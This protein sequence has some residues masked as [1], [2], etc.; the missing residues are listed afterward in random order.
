MKRPRKRLDTAQRGL[1]LQEER[2]EAASKPSVLSH[3]FFLADDPRGLYVGEE[4]LDSYLRRNRL[5]WVIRLRSLLEGLDYS[6]LMGPYKATG[7]RAVSPRA[8]L[9][10]IVYGI[11]E[12]QSSLRELE[13]LAVRDVGAWW[14][15][16]GN[17]PD[18]STIGKFIQT[19][20]EALS[21]EF[22]MGLV[23][24]LGGKMGLRAGA[25]AADGTVIEAAASRYSLIRAEAAREAAETARR[26]AESQAGNLEAAQA[27]QAALEVAEIINERAETRRERGRDP[28][29]VKIAP[30]EPEA[31]VQTRK[32]GV[33][34]P[35]YKP[36][37]LVHE[38]GLVVGQWVDASSEI[39]AIEPMLCQHAVAFEAMPERTLID[40]GYWSCGYGRARRG[41]CRRGGGM[42]KAIRRQ[43]YNTIGGAARVCERPRAAGK[44]RGEDDFDRTRYGKKFPKS[45]F[46]YNET[47]DAYRCPG[48]HELHSAGST[49]DQWGRRSQIYRTAACQGC[50][51]RS[52]CTRSRHGRSI[53]RYEHDA[54][55][56]AM[57]E[58]FQQPRARQAYRKRAPMAE[59]P[60]AQLRERLGLN[61]FGRRGLRGARVKFALHIIAF[62]LKKAVGLPASG[63]V[64]TLWIAQPPSRWHLAAIAV[65]SFDSR[66]P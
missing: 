29:T 26:E 20:A 27:A 61:R 46:R 25:V 53:K 17:Q 31:V 60:F 15:S 7:R 45:A 21:E 35:A 22:F 58:V 16:G 38:S 5:E 56:E 36:S 37:V 55:K 34:R 63:A 57:Q 1:G 59:T 11:M 12:R 49:V 54:V 6:L 64:L 24:T 18:H 42:K 62:D 28:Q 66:H 8:M 41:A 40:A 43:K 10:L 9:G 48:G 30:A 47:T 44:A 52:R 13:E 33:V 51:L 3:D 50:E 19:H 32:D 23:K 2:R 4:R 65:V 14:V 39:A